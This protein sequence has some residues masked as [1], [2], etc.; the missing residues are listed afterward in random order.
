MSELEASKAKLTTDLT[1]ATAAAEQSLKRAAKI[2]AKMHALEESSRK[3]L[4]TAHTEHAEEVKEH[5][6]EEAAITKLNTGKG[7]GEGEGEVWGVRCEM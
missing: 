1:A 3:E 4:E 5:V 2:E 7:E 6:R